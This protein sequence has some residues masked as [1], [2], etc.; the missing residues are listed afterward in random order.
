MI[1]IGALAVAALTAFA[2]GWLLGRGARRDR[3]AA[4]ADVQTTLDRVSRD[5][6]HDDGE[7]R[8]AGPFPVGRGYLALSDIS[9]GWDK[10]EQ[11]QRGWPA[12]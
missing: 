9:A 7:Q 2:V 4:I 6:E 12:L 10:I 1:L 5:H 3:R 11:E 8:S